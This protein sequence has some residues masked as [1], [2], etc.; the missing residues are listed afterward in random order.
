MSL[1]WKRLIRFIAT[2][3]RT[4]RGEPILPTPTTDLGFIT[5]SD[6]LQVRVIEGDDLYDTTGKTRI[7]DEIVSV[8]TVLGPLAQ[9]DVPILRC[10]GL[11]YAKH[12]RFPYPILRKKLHLPRRVTYTYIHHVYSQ[13]S[14]PHPTPIPIHLLQAKYH[15][16]RSWRTSSNPADCPGF[17]GR[18]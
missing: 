12:G 17:T 13:R 14:R 10:V 16:P 15:N 8:K 5:E 7:T 6:K 11:N 2:D 18:L 1:P 3:G 9:A 4:L